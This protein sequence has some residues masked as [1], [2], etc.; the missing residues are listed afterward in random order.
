M[1]AHGG[2]QIGPARWSDL[3]AIAAIESA[4]FSE[5]STV[6]AWRQR[7]RRPGTVVLVARRCNPVAAF[8]GFEV[9]GPVAHVI[10]N[11]TRPE[12]Q[13]RGLA[14]ALLRAGE[15][16]ARDHG[17]RWFQGEVRCGN[18]VQLALLHALG[19]SVIGQCPRFFANGEDAT[20]LW[21]LLP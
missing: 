12:D 10:G 6:I 9:L 5:P 21:L 7:W 8:F 2:Y 19:W 13:R 20:I 3:P 14:T 17:A 16:V 1:F 11:A 15:V 4:V 18:E